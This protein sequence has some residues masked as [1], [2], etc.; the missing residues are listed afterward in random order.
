MYSDISILINESS[1]ADG[2]SLS[3]TIRLSII[4]FTTVDVLCFGNLTGEIDLTITGN[5]SFGFNWTGPASFIDPGT[6]DLTGLESGTYSVIVTDINGCTFDSVAIVSQ[7][8]QIFLDFIATS[9]I[10]RYDES[11]LSIHIS[12]AA[13]NIYTVLLQ[14]SILKSFV[15]D[16]NGFLIPEEVP[17]IL[18]PNFS[19]EVSIISL[20]DNNG[21]EGVFNDDVHIEVKQLPQLAINEENICFGEPSYT[22]NN[23]TPSGGT[24]FINNVMTNYFDVENLEAGDYSIRYEYT[25]PT[26]PYCYNKI[27]EVVTINQSPEP[28]MHF[29]PQPTDIDDS[30][31]L[32]RDNSNE[33]IIE[34][35]YFFG[36]SVTQDVPS[37]KKYGSAELYF[38]TQTL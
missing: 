22:L 15:I 3:K 33:N 1:L 17:I 36:A 27:T 37:S 7:T 13:A 31:I 11:I 4:S 18:T 12:N 35:V 14:D 5:G 38:I 29:S 16:T 8:E 6:E 10:C 32:F 2:G 23:A 20:T 9:P 26:Y 25:E 24:Y 30:D 34:S 21:C 19:G 28:E